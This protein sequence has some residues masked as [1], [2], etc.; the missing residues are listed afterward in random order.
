M[1]L[2]KSDVDE[3]AEEEDV[4]AYVSWNMPYVL[5]GLLRALVR[6]LTMFCVC[7]R[8]P[9]SGMSLGCAGPLPNSFFFLLKKKDAKKKNPCPFFEKR[10]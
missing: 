3:R 4:S 9:R 5:E 8:Q 1:S 6:S 10:P 2:S 7:V